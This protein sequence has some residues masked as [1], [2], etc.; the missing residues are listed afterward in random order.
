MVGIDRRIPNGDEVIETEV[1]ETEVIETEPTTIAAIDDDSSDQMND[2]DWSEYNDDWSEYYD[3]EYRYLEATV[4]P[5]QEAATEI[6]MDVEQSL[7]E[8]SQ[9][10][11]AARAAIDAGCFDPPAD[12]ASMKAYDRYDDSY[13]YAMATVMASAT[14]TITSTDT[15]TNTS[16]SSTAPKKSST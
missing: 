11:Q 15:L 14:N 16:R 10:D 7:S 4:Q 2:E 1:I 9:E 8:T 5:T 13:G 6:C 12:E 3:L